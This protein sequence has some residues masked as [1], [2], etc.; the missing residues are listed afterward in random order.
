[1]NELKAGRTTSDF[2]LP[3]SSRRAGKK[4]TLSWGIK[5]SSFPAVHSG[6]STCTSFFRYV[7][8]TRCVFVV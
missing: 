2:S 7:A 1:M 6:S 4:R 5:C 3:Q 8:S